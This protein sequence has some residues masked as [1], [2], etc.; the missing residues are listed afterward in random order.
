MFDSYPDDC[1]TAFN[2]ADRHVLMGG[3]LFGAM[4]VAVTGNRA[5]CSGSRVR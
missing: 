5:F 2:L 3:L 1:P 4:H